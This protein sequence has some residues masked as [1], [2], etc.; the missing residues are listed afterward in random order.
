MENSIELKGIV[1]GVTYR[2]RDN[3]YTVIKVKSGKEQI[4]AAG[5]MP[6]FSEGD[7]VVL[8]GSYTVHSVYGRQFKVDAAEATI[9]Q[10]SLQVLKFLSSGAI[11]GVGPSTATKIVERF[12]D[13]TLEIIE[14]EPLRLSE[15]R[16]I[17]E[18]K[19]LLISEEYKKQYG[20]RDIMLSLSKFK[21]TPIEASNIFKYLGANC[22]DLIKE[23][24][25]YLCSE[26]IGFPFERV[27][28]IAPVNLRRHS[29][30]FRIRMDKSRPCP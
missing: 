8:F 26:E 6:Y 1:L 21:I 18:E 11:K 2:N 4:T 25:Y 10:N 7:S 19:A 29:I 22:V 17:S 27:E 24:P 3:G 28:E 5:I 14:N 30:G 15:I 9:P 13:R 20:I 12:K 16:G 23:N